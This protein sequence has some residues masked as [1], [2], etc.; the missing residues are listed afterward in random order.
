MLEDKNNCTFDYTAMYYKIIG[1][2]HGDMQY[3]VGHINDP[4]TFNPTGACQPGGIYFTD[5]HHIH[6]YWPMFGTGVALLRVPH[7]TPVYQDPGKQQWK[8]PCIE[9]LE[10]IDIYTLNRRILYKKIHSPTLLFNTITQH[11]SNKSSCLKTYGTRYLTRITY[12]DILHLSKILPNIEH[13]GTRIPLCY[14]TDDV[15]HNL[16]NQCIKYIETHDLT[17][18]VCWTIL[19]HYP[20]CVKHVPQRLM[21][22]H[23]WQMHIT[24][25]PTDFHRIPA[26]NKTVV[27]CQMAV[28]LWS[29]NIRYVPVAHYPRI[30]WIRLIGRHVPE[31]INLHKGEKIFTDEFYR[32]LRET[33][34]ANNPDYWKWDHE[35][36]QKDMRNLQTRLVAYEESGKEVLRKNSTSGIN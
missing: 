31:L 21:T 10:I 27:L 28:E 30:N 32:M 9:I 23:M 22:R 29:H 18:D 26:Q 2:N 4:Q 16:G 15:L 1:R 12:K 14:L 35:M 36:S 20:K 6:T 19:K 24:M 17:H 34:G 7:G 33:Y 8:A 25:Y 3:S 5:L 11:N 13:C